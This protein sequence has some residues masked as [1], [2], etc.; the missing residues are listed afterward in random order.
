ME[1]TKFLKKVRNIFNSLKIDPSSALF[2]QE[3]I[4]IRFLKKLKKSK[5]SKDTLFLKLILA[6][7]DELENKEKIP[8]RVDFSEKIEIDRSMIYSF[9]GPFQLIHADVGNL[10]F[11]GKS[12]TVP[13]YAL[14]IV[15]LYSSEV[16]VYPMPSRK[17]IL[18]IKIFYDEVKD[19]RKNKPMRLQ[20]DNKFQQVKI[21]DLNDW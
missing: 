5:Y 13:K 20:V 21:K 18:Q 8:T 14:L 6:G 7:D 9:D 2:S 12:T 17:Q 1:D 19:K 4:D 16:C 15:D 3:K 11:L 10:E